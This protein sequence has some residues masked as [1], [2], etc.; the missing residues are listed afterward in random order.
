M[1]SGLRSQVADLV[2]QKAEI[3]CQ[4]AEFVVEFLISAID[5]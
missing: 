3:R 1:A 5:V 2:S 4:K